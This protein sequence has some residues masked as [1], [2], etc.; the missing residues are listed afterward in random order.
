MGETSNQFL[1]KRFYQASLGLKMEWGR[2]EDQYC[3]QRQGGSLKEQDWPVFQLTCMKTEF[4]AL[5][6][7][8][9]LKNQKKR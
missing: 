6:T 3:S 9:G 1:E 8:G 2:G 5:G 7:T 4:W